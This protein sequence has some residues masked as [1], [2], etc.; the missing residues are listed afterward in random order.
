MIVLEEGYFLWRRWVY[1]LL[2]R[3]KF[4]VFLGRGCLLENVIWVEELEIGLEV[5]FLRSS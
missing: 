4:V 1:I 5:D 2:G 3:E